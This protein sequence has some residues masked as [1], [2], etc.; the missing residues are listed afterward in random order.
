MTAFVPAPG[1]VLLHLDAKAFMRLQEPAWD[2]ALWGEV[3]AVG[4]TPSPD[5]PTFGVPGD[6]V[7]F[8]SA[9]AVVMKD[10]AG[11]AIVAVQARGLVA[12]ME[13]K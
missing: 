1:M 9:W 5:I 2:E 8:T 12:K 11:G 10:D 4:E 6:V 13:R 7:A 3:I